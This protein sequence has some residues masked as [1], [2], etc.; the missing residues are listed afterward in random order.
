MT[1]LWI[2][3]FGEWCKCTSI[4]DP[5]VFGLLDPHP[6]PFLRGTYPGIRIR[7][8][9]SRIL[10]N[11]FGSCQNIF[12]IWISSRVDLLLSTKP[13]KSLRKRRSQKNCLRVTYTYYFFGA[14][15]RK[16]FMLHIKSEWGI[17]CQG[18]DTVQTCLLEYGRLIEMPLCIVA[19]FK[20]EM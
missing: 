20:V 7:T 18:T 19:I 3:I 4:P 11:A 9:M 13:P 5:Y 8:K 16:K 2:F 17:C 12:Y 14:I 15:I 10:N 6:D 1:S